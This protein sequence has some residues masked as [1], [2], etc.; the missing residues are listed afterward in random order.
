ML[1]LFIIRSYTP[2]TFVPLINQSLILTADPLKDK[3][4][5]KVAPQTV[6]KSASGK[7]TF[8][9]NPG[10]QFN[11]VGCTANNGFYIESLDSQNLVFTCSPTATAGS[12]VLLGSR[13]G[14]PAKPLQLFKLVGNSILVDGGSNL[15][16]TVDS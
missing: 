5:L 2:L 12:S 6:V 15:A 11:A 16:L 3:T 10:Q 1:T 4:Q 8:T 14:E 13:A 9:L 7:T